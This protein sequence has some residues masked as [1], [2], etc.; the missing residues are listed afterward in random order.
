MTDTF[1][2]LHSNPVLEVIPSGSANSDFSDP[3]AGM[4]SDVAAFLAQPQLPD[5]VGR[6]GGYRVLKLLGEGGMGY[7][8]LAEDGALQRAVAL[9]VMKP[10]VIC[11]E[12][13]KERF[14]RE[15]R[16][17]ARVKHDHVITIHQV[18]EE[19]GVPYLALE[20]LEGYSLDKAL[21]ERG[22]VS[23]KEAV[24]ITREIASGLQAAHRQGLIHRDIKPANIWLEAPDGRV[25]ILDF[26]LARH[27]VEDTH[28]T[29]TGEVVGTPAYMSPEQARD[30]GIDHR[31]DLFSL[32]II[33]YRLCC[34]QQ[35]FHGST[36]MAILT[37]LAVDDPIM[38]SQHNRLIPIY[39]EQVILRLLEKE[40]SNRYQSAQELVEALAAIENRAG[41]V[42]QLQ[43]ATEVSNL[44]PPS[45]MRAVPRA[46]EETPMER[47]LAVKTSVTPPPPSEPA[48]APQSKT[49]LF[50]VA[51]LLGFCVA[52]MWV[53][54]F[55]G[56]NRAPVGMH[57]EAPPENVEPAPI[58][59]RERPQRV[60]EAP[61]TAMAPFETKQARGFQDAWA[62][63]LGEPVEFE[64]SIRMP[65]VLIP[66]GKFM[67]GAPD[68]EP[69]STK[70]EVP[71]H[72]VDITR[73]FYLGATEVTQEQYERVMKSNPSKFKKDVGGGPNHPVEQISWLDADAFCQK[74]SSLPEEAAAGRVYRLPTEAEWEYACRAGTQ[75]AY[76]QATRPLGD[77]AWYQENTSKTQPVRQRQPNPWGLFDMTGNVWEWCSDY[78][79]ETYYEQ[80]ESKDPSG[81]LA[82]ADRVMRGGAWSTPARSCRSAYRTGLVPVFRH[83][84]FGFRVCYTIN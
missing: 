24:R 60:G 47:M 35:P 74:L 46:D 33:L 69:S 5:E 70:G 66:P 72:E 32:G 53:I 21:K 54:V 37:S 68:N 82:G 57:D 19:R 65:L 63:H 3:N 44:A 52:S 79:Q 22:E 76:F 71:Q 51:G 73:P 78:Y 1:S 12:N 58:K 11:E 42:G 43:A 13:A 18:G 64:N 26:G 38:P 81:P 25:K 50:F 75:T 28:L 36:T 59:P 7:V 55:K 84:T 15:A 77:Y 16:A 40:A 39:L 41:I 31:S 4:P 80:K 20:Y 27:L 83:E 14:F 9:K 67:M 61:P 30:R 6:L 34:G 62:K 29:K 56:Q 10:D 23:L 48:E 8:F 45:V 17:A 49:R 2:H